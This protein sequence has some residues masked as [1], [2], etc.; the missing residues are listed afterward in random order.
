MTQSQPFF[1]HTKHVE[2]GSKNGK[3]QSDWIAVSQKHDVIPFTNLLDDKV[4]SG[5][6]KSVL[7][8]NLQS[9]GPDWQNVC[10]SRSF[11]TQVNNTSNPCVACMSSSSVRLC[12]VSLP[13]AAFDVDLAAIASTHSSTKILGLV[14]CTFRI[15]ANKGFAAGSL[16]PFPF[17]RLSW[18]T[19]THSHTHTH[20]IFWLCFWLVSVWHKMQLLADLAA[21]SMACMDNQAHRVQHMEAVSTLHHYSLEPR[22]L[23][24]LQPFVPTYPEITI[25]TSPLFF[26]RDSPMLLSHFSQRKSWNIL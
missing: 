6:Q 22:L 5:L 16:N 23:R 25:Q 8:Q 12:S 4:R 11:C 1:Q 9:I 3:S 14:P 18:G 19:N 10:L 21:Y 20:E 26:K 2:T 13:A 7:L 24:L 15:P 17:P